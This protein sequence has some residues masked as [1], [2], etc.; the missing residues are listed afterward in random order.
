VI[1][2]RLL[3]ALTVEGALLARVADE[4]RDHGLARAPLQLV[5]ELHGRVESALAA[6]P[7]LDRLAAADDGVV[8]EHVDDLLLVVDLALYLPLADVLV[9]TLARV[10]DED[11]L[12]V[13]TDLFYSD[14]T[15]HKAISVFV[16]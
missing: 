10:L 15:C 9:A 1:L 11:E 12:A 16:G 13:G 5:P 4:P 2:R 3:R 14:W 7:D 6:R 8:G